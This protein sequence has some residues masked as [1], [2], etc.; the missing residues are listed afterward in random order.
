LL[1]GGARTCPNTWATNAAC[2]RGPFQSGA[3]DVVPEWDARLRS[4][5][6]SPALSR[7]V[8]AVAFSCNPLSQRGFSIGET[9]VE[10]RA[11][12]LAATIGKVHAS[13]ITLL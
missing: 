3:P 11:I 13:V 12:P 10:T 8:C 1:D 5:R 7:G 9:T 6:G 4:V 2:N